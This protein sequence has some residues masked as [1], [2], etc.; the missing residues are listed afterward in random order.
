MAEKRDYY[1]V[2][3]VSKSATQDELKKAHRK[4]AKKYHPDLNQGDKAKEAEEKFKEVSE[5]YEVLS[6]PEK[7]QRYDQFGHAAFD[8]QAGGGYE[9]GGFG[10]GFDGFGD[11]FE[12]FFGGGF[13]G[14]GAR[15]NPNAPQKGSDLQYA[16]ELT[17][18]EAC[19]GC[20]KEISISR[21]EKCE[22]CHGSGAEKG[23]SPVRCATCGGT[24]QVRTVQRTPFGSFQS[25]HPCDA[26]HGTGQIIKDPCK[27][28]RG[29][30]QTR[31]S[32]K[33]KVSIPAGIND[34]QMISMSGQG[35]A[36][37]N[38]GP[39]GDLLVV[40]RVK[41]HKVFT[42]RGYDILCEF[43]ITFVEATLGAEIEVPTIDEKLKFNIPEGTQ[44][45]KVFRLKGKGVPKLHGGGARGDQ[46]VTVNIEIPKNLT[47]KQKDLLR[48]FGETVE[49]TKYNQKKTFFDKIK[50]LFD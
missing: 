10:G 40:T 22:T 37:K 48:Q 1:E 2:L 29:T 21:T 33:I 45:G 15:R 30:G 43:P 36:G 26:C 47:E 44:T 14:G 8:P 11:I 50:D 49:D 6:D 9:A 34:G 35:N 31:K 39:N 20:E 28:C 16:V 42:R 41:N 19:F 38:G 24:G 18:E 5:A 12:S 13:G 3:G 46:Y 7:R 23:S 17:F 32:R 25:T 4:L 27:T